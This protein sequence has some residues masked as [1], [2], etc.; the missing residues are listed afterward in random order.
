MNDLSLIAYL[1]FDSEYKVSYCSPDLLALFSLPNLIGIHVEELFE[2]PGISTVPQSRQTIGSLSTR[3]I[4]RANHQEVSAQIKFYP[5][6]TVALLSFASSEP[7]A[8]GNRHDDPYLIAAFTTDGQFI[9]AN[10]KWKHYLGEDSYRL[11]LA[12]LLTIT[13]PSFTSPWLT[14]DTDSW[15]SHSDQVWISTLTSE[16][17]QEDVFEWQLTHEPNTSLILVRGD[18]VGDSTLGSPYIQDSQH[19]PDYF[20]AIGICHTDIHGNYIRVNE[21]FSRMLGYSSDELLKMSFIDVT[22]PEDVNADLG[23][24]ELLLAG[25]IKRFSMEKRYIRKDGQTVWAYLTVRLI[26]HSSMGVNIFMAA[27]SDITS[28]SRAETELAKSEMYFRNLVD[29]NERTYWTADT[30]GMILNISNNAGLATG[31]GFAA[32]LGEGWKKWVYKDD[33]ERVLERWNRSLDTGNRYDCDYRILTT[34][35]TVKWLRSQAIAYR[36]DQGQVL[37]W[38]GCTDDIQT[39]KMTEEQLAR[40]VEARTAELQAT[41]LALQEAKEHAQNASLAKS[42]FLANMSHEFRTPLNGIIGIVSILREFE[43]D[44]KTTQMINIIWQS[45]E[46]LLQLISGILDFAKI[47]AGRVSLELTQTD[48][49]G[50]LDEICQ[51]Y[52]PLADNKGVSLILDN[53]LESSCLVQADQLRLRQI[54][55]NLTTNAVKFTRQG[56]VVIQIAGQRYAN[57]LLCQIKITDTGIG[58]PPERIETLFESFTQADSTIQ[59]QFGGTG[60]G[61]SI[62]KSLVELMNGSISIRSKLGFGTEVS[63]AIPF[64]ICPKDAENTFETQLNS[65]VVIKEGLS[66]LLAEDNP[67]NL[68]VYNILLRGHGCWIDYATDG[69]EAIVLAKEKRYDLILMDV[70]MPKCDGLTATQIIRLN[71]GP[72]KEQPIYALISSDG[73]ENFNLCLDAGMSGFLSKPITID[74]LQTVLSAVSRPAS[75]AV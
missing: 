7:A 50:I 73:T 3:L 52:K 66:V 51:L 62:T 12:P 20:D 40:L 74:A 37:C 32:L 45:S 21:T 9:S 75:P 10:S 34:N 25:D 6:R 2:D 49:I 1:E 24:S 29:P 69:N 46:T 15:I 28:K 58:I 60:L 26:R 65:T 19:D 54:V 18:R 22:H 14:A 57:D 41:N 31:T 48:L 33:K 42:Q 61:L 23:Q 13:R 17:G 16:G 39:Q 11:N 35:S 67:I 38:Y 68:S 63:I 30:N 56:S 70:H 44:P 43:L 71:E 72:N 5:E 47:E 27:V 59:R 4:V 53:R 8:A 55:S 36:D 64:K